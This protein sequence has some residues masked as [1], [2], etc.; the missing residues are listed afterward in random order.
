MTSGSPAISPFGV[1]AMAIETTPAKDEAAPLGHAFLL[2]RQK[3]LAV[4]QPP[5]AADL[6]D[7]RSV[8]GREAHEIAVEGAQ[9][10]RHP[11]RPGEGGML[12]QVQRLAMRRHGDPGPQPGVHFGKLRPARMAGDV[13]QRVAVGDDLDARRRRRR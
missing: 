13:H 12:A 8:A 2:G 1:S 3:D 11:L 6:A 9:N 10:L 5:A 7:R 4:L